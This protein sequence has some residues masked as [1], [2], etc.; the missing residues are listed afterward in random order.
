MKK[1]L[2]ITILPPIQISS[3]S[4]RDDE[5]HTPHCPFYQGDSAGNSHSGSK[6]RFVSQATWDENYERS[7]PNSK[8]NRKPN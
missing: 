5:G 8:F 7:F 4:E 3:E 1:T 6:P 2:N